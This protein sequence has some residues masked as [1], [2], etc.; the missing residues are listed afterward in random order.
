MGILPGGKMDVRMDEKIAV[1]V[2]MAFAVSAVAGFAVFGLNPGRVTPELVGIYGAAFLF[3]AQGQVWVTGAAF[4][5]V[6]TRRSGFQW[7]LAFALCYAISLCSE[8]LGTTYGVPFGA[9][10]YS[11]TLGP[12]WIERVPVIVPISWFLMALP[13]YGLAA[14]VARRPWQR[15][16]V[17]SLILLLWD[18]VL[19]PAM[20]H[21]TKYW[22][23]SEA[24]PYFG[25]PLFNLFGWY[26]TG[27][28]LLGALHV[29]RVTRW[30]ASVPRSV[31]TL[32][33]VA[34]LVVPIGM[35]LSAVIS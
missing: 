28:A 24:G 7:V 6:L 11:S 2:A 13:S 14:R 10:A 19:D 25:M 34:N 27:L 17:G 23:W 9:Y 12:M 35:L 26:V 29:L 20:S 1:A 16:L 30:M 31:W 33:Y 18:L 32:F 15:I 8:L 4:A 5:Y 21:V 22:S 3:F